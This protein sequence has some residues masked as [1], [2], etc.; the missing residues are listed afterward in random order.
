VTF[1]LRTSFISA[2]TG[3][4]VAGQLDIRA[5]RSRLLQ[6]MILCVPTGNDDLVA[7]VFIGDRR[8][9]LSIICG[10]VTST[11]RQAAPTPGHRER[12]QCPV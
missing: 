2:L 7:A 9:D 4:E 5:Q 8:T 3:G 6:Q 11:S 1:R 12:R 10:L